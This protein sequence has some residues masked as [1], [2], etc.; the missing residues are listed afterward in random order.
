MTRTGIQDKVEK[1]KEKITEVEIQG[2][3]MTEERKGDM[4]AAREKER[5]LKRQKN[6]AAK[7][8]M[9]ESLTQNIVSV[10]RKRK[11]KRNINIGQGRLQGIKALDDMMIPKEKATKTKIQLHLKRGI[12]GCDIVA[13]SF[14]YDIVFFYLYLC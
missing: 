8:L 10:G 11:A 13:C 12:Y 4:K 3:Q 1:K 2:R 9:T 7:T 14:I 5:D 6:E